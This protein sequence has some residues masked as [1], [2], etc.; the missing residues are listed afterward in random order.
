MRTKV[1]I[2]ETLQGDYQYT[3]FRITA[4]HQPL[5]TGATKRG[6]ATFAEAADA[7]DKEVRKTY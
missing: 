6:F 5:P 2:L 3:I 7:A 4:S 1:E